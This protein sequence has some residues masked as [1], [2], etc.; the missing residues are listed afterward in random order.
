[1]VYITSNMILHKLNKLYADIFGLQ[2][3]SVEPELVSIFF[4]QDN[5]LLQIPEKVKYFEYSNFEDPISIAARMANFLFPNSVIVELIPIAISPEN[6]ITIFTK[7]LTPLEN[8][9]PKIR[10]IN[11]VSTAELC[12]LCKKRL[13]VPV[14][15]SFHETDASERLGWRLIIHRKLVK[16]LYYLMSNFIIRNEIIKFTE[17]LSLK[18]NSIICDVASGY[19]NLAIKIAKKYKSVAILNDTI[20]RPII[21]MSSNKEYAD[22]LFINED[23]L[24]L[25]LAIKADLLICKNVLHHLT[26]TKEINEMFTKI[27]ELSD[28]L[29]IIDPEDPKKTLLGRFWNF[30][31]TRFLLDQGEEFI[32]FASFNA[33]ISKYFPSDKV[34]LKK[35]RT[36]KGP[37]MVAFVDKR[38]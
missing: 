8:I 17:S 12:S 7:I 19:D 20:S 4:N 34:I 2:R 22:T 31:Y 15:S 27:S 11:D 28:V 32:S 30:Y 1:M 21:K 29:V 14:N 10:N 13:S 36:I 26:T 24:K 5:Q 18:N 3:L 9:Q 33:L 37:F 16:P 35:I 38:K 6:H 25:Q 23:S